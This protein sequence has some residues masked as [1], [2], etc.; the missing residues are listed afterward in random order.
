MRKT[1]ADLIV[2]QIVNEMVPAAD[3]IDKL[4][5]MGYVNHFELLHTTLYFKEAGTFYELGDL[6]VDDIYRFEDESKAL[7]VFCVY[8]LRDKWSG[9]K[10][11]FGCET[12]IETK[13][14]L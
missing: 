1:I 4:H 10:G 2:A 13:L 6:A 11:L 12:G 8:A 7:G 3:V 5:I 14:D 9:R